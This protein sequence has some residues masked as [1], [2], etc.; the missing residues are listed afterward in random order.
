MFGVT[1][2]A[3]AAVNNYW[4]SLSTPTDCSRGLASGLVAPN[5]RFVARCRAGRSSLIIQNLD[6]A[7][8]DLDIALN[9]AR[10]WR[11]AARAGD[12][13]EAR[14]IEDSRSANRLEF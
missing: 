9:K 1:A 7:A 12:I 8:P 10:P 13:Y 3:H 4:L 5:G 14:R 2:Q 11:R 6:R